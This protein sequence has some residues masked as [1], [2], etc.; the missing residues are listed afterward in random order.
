M[1]TERYQR[2]PLT[3]ILLLQRTLGVKF[4]EFLAKKTYLATC[5]PKTTKCV[6]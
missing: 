2:D 5:I 4:G 3:I 1:K 6:N